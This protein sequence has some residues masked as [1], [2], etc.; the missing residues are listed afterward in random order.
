MSGL[1]SGGSV[2]GYVEELRKMMMVVF[3]NER[4]EE[5]EREGAC[6]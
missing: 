3:S 2:T 1:I 4:K 5:R 6:E